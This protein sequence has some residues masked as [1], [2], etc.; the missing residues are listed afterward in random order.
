M[1]IKYLIYIKYIKLLLFDKMTRKIITALITKNMIFIKRNLCKSIF[2]LFYPCLFLTF[3]IFISR[4][5]NIKN[6]Q[7]DPK[8]SYYD[9]I[10]QINLYDDNYQSADI[11]GRSGKK[12]YAFIIDN[13]ELNKTLN[14]FL[15]KTGNLS[16][17]ILN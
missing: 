12:S 11:I 9:K 10:P 7:S 16:L 2:Q 3:F 5:A 4:S 13:E 8:T 6:V 15:P 14:E 17:K 1:L